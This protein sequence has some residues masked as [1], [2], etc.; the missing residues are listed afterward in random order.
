MSLVELCGGNHLHRAGDLLRPLSFVTD[1][2]RG[3]SSSRC[4]AEEKPQKHSSSQ[5][6]TPA[7]GHTHTCA[8]DSGHHVTHLLDVLDRLYT[9]LEVAQG[10]LGWGARG[11]GPGCDLGCDGESPTGESSPACDG[12]HAGC[13][14]LWWCG[15]CL[16]EVGSESNQSLLSHGS[17]ATAGSGQR[18]PQRQGP[19][20]PIGQGRGRAWRGKAATR[21]ILERWTLTARQAGRTCAMPRTLLCG[22]VALASTTEWAEGT[23][24]EDTSHVRGHSGKLQI[25]LVYAETQATPIDLMPDCVRVLSTLCIYCFASRPKTVGPYAP[26]S[27]KHCDT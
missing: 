1:G 23:E 13:A 19:G 18:R 8:H 9:A 21:R 17:A 10:G 11:K 25:R 27:R 26:A 22:C 24:A 3:S 12:E 7:A 4:R 16:G 14:M 15:S 2:L 20:Q 5:P 6:S